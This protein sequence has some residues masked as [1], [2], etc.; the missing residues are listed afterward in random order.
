VYELSLEKYFYPLSIGLG[1]V[2]LWNHL[3]TQNHPE[4]SAQTGFCTSHKIINVVLRL[5]LRC[6][7]SLVLKL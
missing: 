3:A 6:S 1:W 4:I 7:F 2:Y 5:T